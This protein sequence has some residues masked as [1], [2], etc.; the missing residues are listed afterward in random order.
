[1]RDTEGHASLDPTGVSHA[2]IAY[3]LWGFAPIYWKLV[4]EFPAPELLA[5]RVLGSLAVAAALVVAARGLRDLARVLRSPRGVLAVALASLL[6]AINWLTFIYAVQTDR[7]LATSLGYFMS[8]LANVVLGLLV[9]GERL[10]RAQ[11]IAVSIAAAGLA[12]QTWQVGELPWIALVLAVSFGLYGLVRKLAP[13]DP[14]PGFALESLCMAPLAVGFLWLLASRG[15][16]VMAGAGAGARLLVAGSGVITAAPLLAFASAARRLPLS[17]LGMFQY[18]SPTLALLVA[19]IFYGESFTPGHGV[20]FGCAWS[21]LAL[22]VWDGRQRS[23]RVGPAPTTAAVA[24]SAAERY[25]GVRE[26]APAPSPE[27]DP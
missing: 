6:L 23:P 4:A 13:A 17:T 18:I 16:A 26:G 14:L 27:V 8:P 22:F 12:F 3:A 9:L 15:E 19:V 24:A 5:Y 1:M 20:G 2:L 11:A 21:A 25:P 10:T 7:I